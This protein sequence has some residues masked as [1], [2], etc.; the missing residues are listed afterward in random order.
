M[1]NVANNARATVDKTSVH[2]HEVRTV[3]YFF[4]G[5][6]GTFDAANPNQRHLAFGTA[7]NTG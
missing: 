4:P 6:I 7:G 1:M 5:I 3:T 2:L